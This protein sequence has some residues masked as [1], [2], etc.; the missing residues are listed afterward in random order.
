[1]ADAVAYFWSAKVALDAAWRTDVECFVGAVPGVVLEVEESEKLSIKLSDGVHDAVEFNFVRRRGGGT[2]SLA[3]GPRLT[4][5]S[6]GVA[7]RLKVE[8]SDGNGDALNWNEPRALLA[9]IPF[10]ESAAEIEALAEEVGLCPK[11]V[12]LHELVASPYR[13]RHGSM[14]FS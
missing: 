2:V 1:M 6:L 14:I 4:L 5:V 13:R 8:L 12:H 3:A 11:R 7:A 9:R 10:K